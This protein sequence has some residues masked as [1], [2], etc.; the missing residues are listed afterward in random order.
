MAFPRIHCS[1]LRWTEYRSWIGIHLF[2][3][4]W[5]VQLWSCLK[6]SF[7]S[8]PF[9]SYCC[10]AA[11]WEEMSLCDDSEIGIILIFSYL[12][13]NVCVQLLEKTPIWFRQVQILF[14]F[15]CNGYWRWWY[16]HVVLPPE[17]AKLLPTDRLLSEV[18]RCS[19]QKLKSNLVN[20]LLEGFV[21]L[22]SWEDE[23]L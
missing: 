19:A 8:S 17:I 5:D 2:L 16:R 3:E 23:S 1:N 13:V 4:W 10:T 18:L 21:M 22:A 9:C 20:R 12:Q 15:R 6:F 7:N 11:L 14:H